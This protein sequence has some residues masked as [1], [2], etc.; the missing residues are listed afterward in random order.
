M[1]AS[2]KE[3]RTLSDLLRQRSHEHGTKPAYIFLP[4]GES[5]R[6]DLSYEELYRKACAVGAR[7]QSSAQPGSRILLLYPSG[8]DFIVG[9]F[10]CLLAGLIA[11]P[12]YPPGGSAGNA[13]V[14]RLSGIL[15]D[16]KPSHILTTS[17]L[18]SAIGS[19][20]GVQGVDC[21]STDALAASS[22]GSF[23]PA[24]ADADT[25]A[26]LQYTSGSTAAPK[27][28][29]VSHGNILHNERMIQLAG[30]HDQDSTFVGW[31]PFYH[32]MGLIGNILQP[33]YLGSTAVLMP[34]AAFLQQPIRWL[35]AISQFAAYTSGGPNF[36]YELCLARIAAE[37]RVG[38]DLSS[39]RLA[40]CGAERIRPA[41]VERF[42]QMFGA[43]GF[44]REAFFACYGLAEAT[45]IV[46][47]RFAPVSVPHPGESASRSN[48]NELSTPLV[49]CGEPVVDTH[50][51]IVDPTTDFPSAPGEMGE[52][53]VQSPSVAAGYWGNSELTE[54]VFRA[55]L[56]GRAGTFL[57]TGDLGFLAGGELVVSGRLKDLIIIRGQNYHPEDLEY[58]AA[59]SHPLLRSSPGAAFSVEIDN[60]EALVVAQ[61]VPRG[62]R[63]DLTPITEAIRDSISRQHGVRVH[64]VLLVDAAG[65]PRT[66]SGKVQRHLCR[67]QFLNDAFRTLSK[68]SVHDADTAAA[69][70]A[71]GREMSLAPE[72]DNKTLLIERAVADEVGSVLGV[73]NVELR[74]PLTALGIDSLTAVELEHRFLQRLGVNIS[75][76][77]LLSGVTPDD[78][79]C[80]VMA[81]LEKAQPTNDIV[82]PTQ[83]VIEGEATLSFEQERLW[84]LSS[85]TPVKS[86]YNISAALP[87]HG[88]VDIDLLRR[89]I[90]A[91]IRHHEMLHASFKATSQGPRIFLQPASALRLEFEDVS[92]MPGEDRQEWLTR[93]GSR[94]TAESFDLAQ[95]PLIRFKLFAFG[96]DDCVLL[97]CAH[98]L[99]AD[100]QSFGTIFSQITVAYQALL[101]GVDASLDL[102]SVQATDF[103]R[104]ERQR[105]HDAHWQSDVDFWK[106]Y[107]EGLPPPLRF[108][109]TTVEGTPRSAP[110]GQHRYSIPRT[111]LAELYGFARAR[112]ATPFAVLLAAWSVVLSRLSGQE[113][114]L[115]AV[116][117]SGRHWP[118]LRDLVGCFAHPLLL[119]CRVAHH[120]RLGDLLS[121]VRDDFIET[122]AHQKI[123]FAQVIEHTRDPRSGQTP[124]VQVMVGYTKIPGSFGQ[125]AGVTF[126]APYMVRATTDLPL[127]I[128]LLER[129]EDL[130]VT[131]TF[132]ETFIGA[133]AVERLAR[134]FLDVLETFVTAADRLVGEVSCAG[135]A[136]ARA[137]PN[138]V[139]ICI[140]ANFAAEPL[141]EFFSFWRQELGAAWEVQISPA[142]LLM[143]P[144]VDPASA[145]AQEQPG[146]NIVLVQ[147]G[148]DYAANRSD[149]EQLLD[150]IEL[151]Q[152][153]SKRPLLVCRP[154]QS[155]E[156]DLEAWEHRLA[157][158]PGVRLIGPDEILS[159]Y[160]VATV[161]DEFGGKMANL[162]FT[163]EFYAALGTTLCRKVRA[164][165][166]PP[167]KALVL[168]CDNTLWKGVCAE[169]GAN[170]IQLDAPRRYLQQF[171][172]RQKEAGMLLCLCS[173]NREEDVWAAFAAHPSMPLGPADFIATRINWHSKS[174][175]LLSLTQELR[176]GADS[177][178]FIDDNPLECAEIQAH[179]PDALTVCLQH[180][181]E[182][183]ALLRNVWAFDRM[184]ITGEDRRKT[185][186]Y[187]QDMERQKIAA[188]AVTMAQFLQ[189]LAL[190]VVIE[191]LCAE[192][193]PRV[194]QLSFRVNQFN[195]TLRRYSEAELRQSCFG[196]GSECL[197]V[198]VR[199][200]F[201]DYGLVGC[202]IFR[203]VGARLCVE[204]FFLSCRALGRR[205]EDVMLNRL[206]Q[207]AVGRGL[208]EIEI[209]F[210]GSQRN[211]PAQEFVKR[212]GV[213][214]TGNIPDSVSLIIAADKTSDQL[215]MTNE[216]RQ[217]SRWGGESPATRI[218]DGSSSSGLALARIAHEFRD[219]ETIV[220][221]VEA[222][223]I[224]LVPKHEGVG[225]DSPPETDAEVAIAAIWSDVIG[226]KVTDVRR[227]FFSLGGDSL[228]A[229]KVLSRIWETFQVEI[230][231]EVLFA[232]PL[233]VREVSRAVDERRTASALGVA[234]SAMETRVVMSL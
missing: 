82:T 7:L 32:D 96:P 119:R 66:S 147:G 114:L 159:T 222:K 78:I 67:E 39:W 80:K 136:P 53:W 207:L 181:H 46:S 208:I 52:I 139:K 87:I 223:K 155:H 157:N 232:G 185:E 140:A 129:E 68:H 179:Y 86:A 198:H 79:T 217:E 201:G 36:A 194:S 17:V 92:S 47:G 196:G 31:L 200:R 91:V 115:L 167:Y 48:G 50:I 229:V 57:R 109:S 177:I 152:G 172:A 65:I 73:V 99:V 135:P 191:P 169:D 12:A 29:M 26:F 8:L 186:L 165:L 20:G 107:L 106:H 190:V 11:V 188:A 137:A 34:P 81:D 215:E 41:T 76:A 162:P 117:V 38:L 158:I 89:S 70:V 204:A 189:N 71:P 225:A 178:I 18:E 100:A 127:F 205:V 166:D 23:I 231:L 133:A 85:I 214:L 108:A 210:R 64:T 61:G 35:R 5:E 1:M 60:A 132:Q 49:S 175:N 28:V 163:Q 184:A 180:A 51:A 9:F 176:I 168:D 43:H 19:M 151:F 2:G 3:P 234:Q 182:I 118:Q 138:A 14:R 144:F 233:T 110:T 95:G 131:I 154:A 63:D 202:A 126:D 219:V 4:D 161:Y 84:F 102:L 183:P 128:N 220:R 30:R 206:G 75:A 134:D 58:T 40:F 55:S 120:L 97:T 156:L 77:L 145:F 226:V 24:A 218:A 113:E 88:R 25:I 164:L 224:L 125:T 153:R 44:R 228:Q 90:D 42:C 104:W 227:D 45:L 146:V 112:A 56:P 213:P 221:A 212:L 149:R 187:R 10:G 195:L 199:D 171:V 141:Q 230:P 94:D 27:G 173:K 111:L 62:V 130:E 203:V 93:V 6:H 148:A 13:K 22:V 216:V 33:L 193:I 59:E 150:A 209:P 16:A 72:K 122:F 143:A 69:A 15:Q 105:P 192:Q 174:A 54:R 211:V 98:H 83:A 123:G 170:G 197:A 21:I 160:P 121:R 142:G 101:E 37:D 74:V 103:A 124:T 116:P